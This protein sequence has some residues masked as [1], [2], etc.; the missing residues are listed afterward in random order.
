MMAPILSLNIADDF[1]GIFR[2]YLGILVIN[3]RNNSLTNTAKKLLVMCNYKSL[4][5]KKILIDK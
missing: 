2:L 5:L 1:Y 4:I 3:V